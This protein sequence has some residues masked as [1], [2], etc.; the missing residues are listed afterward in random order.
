MSNF[1]FGEASTVKTLTVEKRKP[2]VK[3]RRIVSKKSNLNREFECKFC[4]KF[5]TTRIIMKQHEVIHDDTRN[6]KCDYCGNRFRNRCHLKE[7]L[8]IHSDERNYVCLY[9]DC[10]KAFKTSA[11]LRQHNKRVHNDDGSV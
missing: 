5:F 11:S 2:K 1:S 7:H 3:T 10:A 8:L 9:S 6:L 4:G